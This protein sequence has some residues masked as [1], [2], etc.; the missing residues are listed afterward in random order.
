M[1]Q[2]YSKES[3]KPSIKLET[4]SCCLCNSTESSIISEGTDYE[5]ESI[6]GTFTFHKC[7]K[8]NHLYLNPRPTLS[9][10]S[11]LYPE[12]YKYPPI[13]EPKNNLLGKVHFLTKIINK[14]TLN[15][16]GKIL[17]SVPNN[18]TVL[19][20]GFGEGET[21][22]LIKKARKDCCVIG[23]DIKIDNKVKAFLEKQGIT[24]KE[25]PFEDFVSHP[26]TIDLIIM[27][28]VIEH[29]WNLQDCIKKVREIL[30][31][32][33]IV[34]VATPNGA[35]YDRKL[36]ADGC[37]GGFYW[38]RHLNIFTPESLTKLFNDNKLEKVKIQFLLSPVGWGQSI[39]NKLKSNGHKNLAKI[40][41]PFSPVL[42]S[43]FTIMEICALILGLQTSN[44]QAIF[45]KK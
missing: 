12:D 7:K 37:W 19:E 26:D 25:S 8:C 34:V 11:L 4:V 38:P 41:N 44:M 29:F 31:P 3:V 10:A 23:V 20:V 9:S 43:I 6:P 42:L 28:Q 17:N 33:G 27:T 30:K 15:R 16:I 21:L 18:G 40:I 1:T 13:P 24:A 2:S 35:G 14:I 39:R 32:G 45:Q 22:A 5:Y 36:W